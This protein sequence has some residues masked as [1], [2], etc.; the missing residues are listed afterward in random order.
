MAVAKRRA[1]SREL[2]K[3]FNILP[4]PNEFPLSLLSF[5]VDNK[6]KYQTNSDIHSTSTN[7]RYKLHVLNTNFSKYQK[8]S[9]LFW[10]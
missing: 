8:K 5:V 9:L 4:L 10:S 3:K 1:S 2:F 7:Y 6:E